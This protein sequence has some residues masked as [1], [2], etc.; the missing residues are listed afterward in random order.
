MPKHTET[1]PEVPPKVPPNPAP[2]TGQPIKPKKPIMGNIIQLTKDEWA[3]WTGGKPNHDWS[4]L[5]DTNTEYT[6]PNQ[7]CPSNASASQKGYNYHKASPLE[8]KFEK[9]SDLQTFEKA[10]AKHLMDTGMDTVAYLPDPVDNTKMN[11][12]VTEHS[13]YTLESATKLAT[14]QLG[15][16]DTYNKVNDCCA[17]ECLLSSLTKDLCDDLEEKLDSNPPFIVAWMQFIKQIKFT[18]MKH[19]ENLKLQSNPA[20]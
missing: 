5:V 18:S 3:A 17:R 2:V 7:L 10:F 13:R 11:F 8:V 16:Y 15:L 9:S 6:S 12:V 19:F 14:P 4:S 1:D 20:V